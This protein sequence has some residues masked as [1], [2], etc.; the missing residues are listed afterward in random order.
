MVLPIANVS[1]PIKKDKYI[2]VI[3]R[4]LM[5]RLMGKLKKVAIAATAGIVRPILARAEP[6]AKL[7]YFV[8]Y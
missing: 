8:I 7:S 3:L 2:K 6:S 4:L 1:A 5:P